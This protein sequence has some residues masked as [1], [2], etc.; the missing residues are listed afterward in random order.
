MAY[1]QERTPLAGRSDQLECVAL[2][3]GATQR[4]MRLRLDGEL[5]TRDSG[6]LERPDARARKNVLEGNSEASERRAGG[7]RLP[8]TPPG[9][10]AIEVGPQPMILGIAVP[11]QPKRSRDPWRL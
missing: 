8:L 3:K 2:V 1:Q 9:E 11:Q 4:L 5:G 10:A 6:C 7:E